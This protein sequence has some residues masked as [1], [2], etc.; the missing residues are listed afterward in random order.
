MK[1]IITGGA[2]FIASHVVDAYIKAGHKVAVIDNLL[3]GFRKNVNPKARFYKADIKNLQLME[4]IMKHERP[5]VVN[6][7]AAIAEVVKS[8]RN[9]IPTM[10]TNVLGTTNVLL[11][12]GKYGR[13]KNKEF[14]F[15]SSGG[16]VYGQ[17]KKFP[18]SENTPLC[19][20]SPYGLSKLLGEEI[21]KFYSQQYNFRYIIFRYPNIYGPRQNPKGEAGV[22]A[23]FG[24]LIKRGLR[25]TIFG[26][27]TKSRDYVYV[28]DIARANTMA[29]THNNNAILNLGWGGS[30]SDQEIFDTV[31]KELRFKQKPIYAPFRRGEVRRSALD[32]RRARRILGWR[33]KVELSEGVKRTIAGL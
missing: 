21:I 33:P 16:T 3:T 5:E 13:G 32:A 12:F 25:P 10:E 19:A 31:A 15:S 8:L 4:R 11:A 9:P 7:H 14:I 23:I 28:G 20:L 1:I 27:G 26:D 22:V 24:G 6:H 17:P 18:V 29:L 30:V 2:G